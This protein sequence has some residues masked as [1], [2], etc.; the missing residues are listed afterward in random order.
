M[1]NK[2]QTLVVFI[3]LLPFVFLLFGFILDKCYLLYRE[4]EL[5]D[6]ADIVCNYA[7]NENKTETEIKQLALENDKDIETIKITRSDSKAEIILDKKQKSMFSKL[8][9]KDSYQIR[10]KISCIE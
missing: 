6:I 4:K 10:V 1:N 3:I 9:G 8:M 5:K 2:G 7:L